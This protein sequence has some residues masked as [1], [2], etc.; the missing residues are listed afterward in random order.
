MNVREMIYIALFA[1][2][3]AVLGLIPP[4]P[5]PFI[6]VPI[7]AQTLGVMLAGSLLGA[8]LGGLS[9]LI[10][11]IIVAAGAP[12]MSGGRGGLA[13]IASPTGGYF[14]SM[15]IAAFV[16]G[17]L[18]ERLQNPIK[19]WKLIIANIIGGILVIYFFGIGYYSFIAEVPLLKTIIGN[20]I[21]IPG[22]IVKVLI[23][24]LVAVRVLKVY[25]IIGQTSRKN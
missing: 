12:L 5:L 1:A 13:V 15:P 22:D 24:S 10:F 11:V 20:F 21:F 17:F 14:L 9:L 3:M 8:R 2:I 6:P 7:T 16:I 23:A 19:F 18:V 4:I 25:P